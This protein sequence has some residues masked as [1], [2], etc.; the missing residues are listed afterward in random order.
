MYRKNL[1]VQMIYRIIMCCVS[2]LGVVLTFGFFYVG[3]PA[4]MTWEFLKYYTNI[5]NYFVFGVSVVVLA[6]NVKRVMAGERE[7][8]NRKIRTFKF[9]TTVMILVTFL[10]YNTMLGNPF[11]LD[12][13]RKI[14]SHC[15]HI[16]APLM[17][18][19]DYFLFEE[20]KCISIYA[21]LFS[22]IIPLVYVAYVFILGAAIK[23][24]EY[25]YFFLD[26]NKI[27]Y[28]G[29][30]IW[31]VILLI[32]FT[33][34]GYLLWLFNR[35]EK[36]NGKIKLDLKNIK[37]LKMPET[38]QPPSMTPAAEIAATDDTDDGQTE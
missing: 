15:L 32:V 18:I 29:V 30:M 36:V 2:A 9:M 5:S 23:D 35:G 8:Y 38:S 7:G 31:V 20:K 10:V 13:W 25:P 6:D 14:S 17:F 28:G 3:K 27:G 34:L 33:G 24:F 12:Y 37:W 4:D 16:I 22:V 19:L 11:H 26:V 1:I 21:P